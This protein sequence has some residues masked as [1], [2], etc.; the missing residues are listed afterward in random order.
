MAPNKKAKHEWTIQEKDE[1][2]YYRYYVQYSLT[3]QA[4]LSPTQRGLNFA[5]KL[6][7][8]IGINP[9][10]TGETGQEK[11]TMSWKAYVEHYGGSSFRV[12]NLFAHRATSP[13]ALLIH[14]TKEGKNEILDTKCEIYVPCWGTYKKVKPELVP[15]L[16]EKAL[17]TLKLLKA[18]NAPVYIFGMNADFSPK[19]AM[20][21][22]Q[23]P[24]SRK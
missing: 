19:H 18:Q 16:K 2:D 21:L 13:G 8:F 3:G 17:A 15:M 7:C 4:E 6:V 22:K 14:E 10:H 1:N 12:T 20:L 5:N 11:T 9:P 23:T 24:A